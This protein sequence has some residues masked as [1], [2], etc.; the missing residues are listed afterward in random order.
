M[1]RSMHTALLDKDPRASIMLNVEK[2]EMRSAGYGQ[3]SCL[4]KDFIDLADE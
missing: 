2:P 3:R 4:F 1:I